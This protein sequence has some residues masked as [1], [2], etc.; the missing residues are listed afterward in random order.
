MRRS[1]LCGFD[2]KGFVDWYITTG[3]FKRECFLEA[4]KTTVIP[5]MNPFP[6]KRSVLI[7][8]NASIHKCTELL[9]LVNQVGGLLL[10]T[11]PYCYDCTPLDNGAFGWVRRYL[12][13]H[14]AIFQQVS[15]EEALSKAFRRVRPQHAR[16]FFKNCQYL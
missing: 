5:H 6:G 16:C 3:T 12:Q 10:F 8:D 9:A 4:V 14:S 15:L 2:V 1:A 13:K 7:L 11:P